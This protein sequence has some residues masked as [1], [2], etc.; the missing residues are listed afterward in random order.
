[1]QHI[2][3]NHLFLF[4]LLL[5]LPGCEI[6]GGIFEAGMWVGIILVIIVIMIIAWIVRKMRR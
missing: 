5:A 3:L 4:F 1:M 6:I 2:K